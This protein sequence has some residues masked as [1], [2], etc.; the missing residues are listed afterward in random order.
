MSSAEPLVSSDRADQFERVARTSVGDR[1]RSITY[2]TPDDH[3]QVYL[4]SD[5]DADADLVGFVEQARDGFRANTAYAD[6]ELGEY[7]YT[8]RRFSDGTL[9]RV[10]SGDEGVFVTAETLTVERAGE[11]ASALLDLLG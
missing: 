5:L 2:F 3:E 8:V 6:S 7:E 1:L 4:R 11:T 9:V 10:T